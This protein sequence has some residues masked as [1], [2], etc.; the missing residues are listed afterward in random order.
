MNM[1]NT[2]YRHVNLL[3]RKKTLLLKAKALYLIEVDSSLGRQKKKGQPDH[4]PDEIN[5]NQQSQKSEL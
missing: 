1:K 2:A 4:L 3:S 5:K